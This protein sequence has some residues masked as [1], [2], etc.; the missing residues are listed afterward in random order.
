[1]KIKLILFSLLSA[2]LLLNSCS[3]GGVWSRIG[4]TKQE[5]LTTKK[6]SKRVYVVKQNATTTI[7][8]VKDAN[9]FYYFENNILVEE[10]EGERQSDYIFENRNR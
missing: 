6:N 9:W 8:K 3:S 2:L 7:Y 4:M 1:M 5:F 10:N